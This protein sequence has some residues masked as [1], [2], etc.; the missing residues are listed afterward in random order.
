MKNNRLGVY[1]LKSSDLN[2]PMKIRETI[3]LYLYLS[4]NPA[5]GNS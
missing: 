3:Q 5:K 1:R 2:L 4:L